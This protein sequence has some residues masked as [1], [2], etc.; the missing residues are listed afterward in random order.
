MSLDVFVWGESKFVFLPAFEW[1]L[2]EGQWH[3][4]KKRPVSNF[5]P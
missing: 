2:C 5:V 4:S 3:T 1:K